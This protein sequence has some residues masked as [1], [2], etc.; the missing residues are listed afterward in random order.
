MNQLC[1]FTNLS[2]S[3]LAAWAQA[4]VGSAAIM[5]GAVAVQWQVRRGRLEL[6]E[7]EARAHDGLATLLIHLKNAAIESRAE[8]RKLERWPPGHPV[9]P[10]SRFRELADAIQR[11][12]LESITAEVPFEAI[13]TA[14][15]ISREIEPLVGPE[16]ELDVNPELEGVFQDY[17]R[18]L[19]QSILLLRVEARR[20]LKGERARHAAATSLTPKGS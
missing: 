15:R 4:I 11:Y 13:L 18:V 3:D 16:P 5:A 20:L 6:S 2:S 17:V 10:S 9:D 7:R 8:K 19:E 1:L 12:P 14:K